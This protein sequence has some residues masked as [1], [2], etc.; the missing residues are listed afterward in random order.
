MTEALC[1][2][3]ERDLMAVHKS[4]MVICISLRAAPRPGT[5]L[6]M[7]I[8]IRPIPRDQLPIFAKVDAR[9]EIRMAVDV[10]IRRCR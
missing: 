7:I 3:A 2:E 4:L 9:F 5:R 1:D 10:R 8:R 6:W